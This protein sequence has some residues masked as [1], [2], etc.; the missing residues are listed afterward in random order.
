L[1]G[2]GLVVG[3]LYSFLHGSSNHSSSK[4]EKERGLTYPSGFHEGESIASITS[5]L[6]VR[7]I[8]GLS[9]KGGDI[10]LCLGGKAIGWDRN[11][12]ELFVWALLHH[13]YVV[14]LFACSSRPRGMK[15][16]FF[17]TTPTTPSF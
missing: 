8:Q 9:G 14:F 15:V 17:S 3:A 10:K 7:G 5:R 11:E 12:L 6:W 16:N 1:Q 4:S 2:Y 13:G